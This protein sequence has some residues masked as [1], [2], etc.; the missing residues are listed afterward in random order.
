MANFKITNTSASGGRGPRSI[1]LTEAGRLL[2]PGE[3][4]VVNRLDRG[5]EALA[6]SGALKVEKGTFEKPPIFTPEEEARLAGVSSPED[7]EEKKAAEAKARAKAE[8]AAAEKQEVEARAKAAADA[9]AAAIESKDAPKDPPMA[10]PIESSKPNDPDMLARA[11]AAADAKAAKIA[12]D[13]PPDD[14]KGKGKGK[15]RRRSKKSG[16]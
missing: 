3:T 11:K 4:C 5:T 10:P 1:F 12:G 8:A 14:D 13:A 9:K 2:K 6:K 7:H 16:G 15:G